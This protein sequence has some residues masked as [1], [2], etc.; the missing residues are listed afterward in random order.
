MF[1]TVLL[2]AIIASTVAQSVDSTGKG[3]IP[4]S[5]AGFALVKGKDICNLQGKFYVG[6]GVDL[7]RK[8]EHAVQYLTRDGISAVFLLS[9]PTLRCGVV[10]AVLDLTP[11]IQSGENAEFKCY[12]DQEGGTTW[13]KWGHIV[14]LANNQ[15]G[16]KRFVTA[17][18][19]WRVNTRQ[20]RFEQIVGKKVTCDT[21]GYTD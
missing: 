11:L 17:R 19:A 7:D 8:K 5:S 20:K 1:G 9:R 12:T 16:R 15:Q 6:T 14:G 21:S 4:F 10:D 13:G 2:L 3:I 18:L